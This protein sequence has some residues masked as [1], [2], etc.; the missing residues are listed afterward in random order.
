MYFVNNDLDKFSVAY[1]IDKR[2]FH[3]MVLSTNVTIK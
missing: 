1:G 3:T 2:D